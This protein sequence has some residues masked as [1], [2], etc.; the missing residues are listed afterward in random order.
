MSKGLCSLETYIIAKVL[1]LRSR[2]LRPI[3]RDIVADLFA[4]VNGCLLWCYFGD[5]AEFLAVWYK[6][7]EGWRLNSNGR[8]SR[9]SRPWKFKL[10]Q[11][12]VLH[13]ITTSR[14][15]QQYFLAWIASFEVEQVSGQ[16]S[17]SDILN[18][19]GGYGPPLSL[20][21]TTTDRGWSCSDPNASN[22]NCQA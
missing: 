14:A 22:E 12:G 16:L 7:L 18:Q 1:I 19:I 17:R 3:I 6:L 21:F 11:T 2:G 8:R 9:S 10:H 13:G 15:K 20:P 4:C 5:R